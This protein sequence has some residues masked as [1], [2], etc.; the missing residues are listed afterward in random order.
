MGGPKTKPLPDWD[1]K[2][3]PGKV[4][5]RTFDQKVADDLKDIEAAK[6]K[7]REWEKES[8]RIRKQRADYEKA[9]ETAWM[10]RRTKCVASLGIL[11]NEIKIRKNNWMNTAI[12]VSKTYEAAFKAFGDLL[13]EE[14]NQNQL[15]WTMAFGALNAVAAGGIVYLSKKVGDKWFKTE[16][17][18][19]FIS[20][21]N[22]SVQNG[23]GALLSVATPIVAGKLEAA[24]I[25]SPFAFRGD[26]EKLLNDMESIMLQWCNEQQ[27]Q[28]RD[29][30]LW[31]FEDFTPQTLDKEITDFLA[32]KDRLYNSQPFPLQGNLADLQA[33]LEKL[34]LGQ[35]TIAFCERE[36][37]RSSWA[38]RRRLPKNIIDKLVS[39]GYLSNSGHYS[40]AD[41][42][43]IADWGR[44]TE[45]VMRG[46]I[47][48]IKMYRPKTF[49]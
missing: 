25:P 47:N 30:Q 36:I 11:A 45:R 3:P 42:L 17:Q 33:E 21:A 27:R 2:G 10:E 23:V 13:D 26:L 12:D 16:A 28:V 43:R 1:P 4:K 19:L 20:A 15:F 37:N 34:M 44:N 49:G 14:T 40:D 5:P 32:E 7:Q 39:V 35:W 38:V 29:M 6:K 24:P 41:T 22:D 9:N 48:S 31:R 46:L 18:Q 8:D